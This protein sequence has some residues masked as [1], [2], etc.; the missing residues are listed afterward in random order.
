MKNLFNILFVV[1]FLTFG[2]QATIQFD[3][4]NTEAKNV[5]FSLYGDYA[6]PEVLFGESYIYVPITNGK[7]N[8]TY[9][10]TK[11]IRISAFIIQDSVT[12]IE[13]SFFLSPGDD[14]T[15]K[16]DGQNI[17]AS[18][19]IT[20][21]GSEN[22]QPLIQSLHGKFI[23]SLFAENGQDTLPNN[24]F[25][26]IQQKA[27]L[28]RKIFKDYA[29]IYQPTEAFLKNETIYMDYFTLICYSTFCYANQ[30]NIRNAYYRNETAWQS[31]EDSL[32]NLFPYN[33]DNL[34][35]IA[36]YA[37]Y[38]DYYIYNRK[39]KLLSNSELM[40]TYFPSEED[41]KTMYND[42]ENLPKEKIIDK[43]FSG[44]M[45]E[46]L[47]AAIFHESGLYLDDNLYEIYE[48][49]VKRYPNSIDIPYIEQRVS[50]ILESRKQII[51]ENTILISNTESLQTFEDILELVKGKTVLLDMWG[52]WCGPCRRDLSKHSETIKTYFKDKSL[53]YLYIA[54]EDLPNEEKWRDL[55]TYYNLTGTH[56]SA[57]KNLSKDILTK[58]N[59]SG[60][61]TYI[62]SKKDGTYEKFEGGHK[63]DPEI[64]FKQI[65][66]ILGE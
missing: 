24:V 6:N 8:W 58:L 22:N 57:N 39:S 44:K 7:L 27:I 18:M 13:Y 31:K 30:P 42:M 34:L 46:F 29:S 2:Q 53:D 32:I 48:R 41:Q 60:Y 43:H 51:S 38:I 47:Y 23:E 52:T 59:S 20:G 63:M 21:K 19:K 35:T 17:L 9:P 26:T 11:P 25:A 1:P 33:N 4:Q 5:E 66:R 55:I 12:E 50:T 36:S 15:F 61:P 3:I 65:D 49:F 37:S 56:I 28:N 14:M 16:A 45:A 54:N 40:K 62:I 64:L 10:V